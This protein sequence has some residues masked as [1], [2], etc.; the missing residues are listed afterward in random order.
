[1]QEKKFTQAVIQG[2]LYNPLGY[3]FKKENTYLLWRMLQA[4]CARQTF[5]ELRI[6]GTK[7]TNGI[8]FNKHDAEPLTRI[9]QDS[10]QNRN[11][12][13]K[14]AYA[15]AY[16]LRKYIGQLCELAGTTYVKKEKENSPVKK[17]VHR[18]QWCN[19]E[20]ANPLGMCGKCFR[21]PQQHEMFPN[22][23]PRPMSVEDYAPASVKRKRK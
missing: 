12:T 6:R 8:G 20:K 16:R 5:D 13:P 2:I 11:L 1:M 22:Q 9:S 14:Q 3:T 10:A 15:V 21:F 7:E 23:T 19:Q 17:E 18:C 4:M